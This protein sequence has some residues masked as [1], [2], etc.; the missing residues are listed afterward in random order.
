MMVFIRTIANPFSQDRGQKSERKTRSR[1]K[2]RDSGKT[3]PGPSSR[4]RIF[5]E[6]SEDSCL[7][8]FVAITLCDFNEF[9]ARRIHVGRFDQMFHI[10]KINAPFKA[11]RIPHCVQFHRNKMQWAGNGETKSFLNFATVAF[12]LDGRERM[13][14]RRH[15]INWQRM[16][17]E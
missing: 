8:F 11:L 16:T 4:T 17:D 10:L 14:V 3:N 6:F 7:Y 12:L 9:R 15:Q 2:R 1:G 5:P 13:L